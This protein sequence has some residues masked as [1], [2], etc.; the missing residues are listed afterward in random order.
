MCWHKITGTMMWSCWLLLLLLEW[1]GNG[2]E[3]NYFY[4]S[5]PNSSIIM[6]VLL[7]KENEE[8]GVKKRIDH[9]FHFHV[10]ISFLARSRLSIVTKNNKF[11][12]WV[13]QINNLLLSHTKFGAVVS[14]FPS[15]PFSFYRS[16]RAPTTRQLFFTSTHIKLLRCIKD[17]VFS[18]DW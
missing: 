16:Y 12:R 13:L 10:I 8:E 18:L 4:Q 14:H 15:A 11:I 3:K 9:F 7:Q 17:N 2:D 6:V 1:Y 5:N